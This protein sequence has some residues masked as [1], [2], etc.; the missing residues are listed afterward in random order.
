[1]ADVI[2]LLVL[3]A[4]GREDVLLRVAAQLEDAHPWTN[5]CP[6]ISVGG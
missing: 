4:F 2:Y 6:P 5:R 3:A 1:V